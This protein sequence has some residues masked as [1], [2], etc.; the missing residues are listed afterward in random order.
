[1]DLMFI[2]VALGIFGIMIYGYSTMN[3]ENPRR[4]L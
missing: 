2:L 3:E 4:G 1:M